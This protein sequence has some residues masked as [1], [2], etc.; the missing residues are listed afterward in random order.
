M[1]E[2][3]DEASARGEDWGE[4][5]ARGARM[6]AWGEAEGVFGADL[7]CCCSAAAFFFVSAYSCANFSSNLY[8]KNINYPLSCSSPVS[9]SL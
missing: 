8:S 2:E 9:S 4:E 1:I 5:E 7:A 3:P 6:M